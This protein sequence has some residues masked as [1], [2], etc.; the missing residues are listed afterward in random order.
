MSND[1]DET[2]PDLQRDVQPAAPFRE[3]G[4]LDGHPSRPLPGPS[5][6]PSA[7]AVQAHLTGEPGTLPMTWCKKCAANVQPEGKGRCPRCRTFL[8]LNFVARRHPVNVLRRDALFAEIVTEY[9]PSTLE[10]RDA[11]RYLANIKERL[12]TTKDGTPEHQ[13]LMTMWS[14]LSVRLRASERASEAIGDDLI[15]ATDD[16]IIEKLLALLHPL[17]DAQDERRRSEASITQAGLSV[18]PSAEPT[19]E[20]PVPTSEPA[21]LLDCRYCG[22]ACVGSDHAAYEALHYDDPEQIKRRDDLATRTM[23]QQIG[24]PLPSWYFE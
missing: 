18:Q 14:E 12:E 11:C 22:R 5:S 19:G 1:F 4:T 6:D 16:Q 10:L 3:D 8:K 23:M 2:E 9:R 13:R 20:A 15:D 21:P 24:K 7:A 17:L